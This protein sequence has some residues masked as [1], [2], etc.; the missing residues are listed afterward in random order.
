LVKGILTV[1]KVIELGP[2]IATVALIMLLVFGELL[3]FFIPLGAFMS[4][5]FHLHRL[6]AEGETLAFFTLGFSLRNFLKPFLVF[7]VIITLLEFVSTFWITPLAKRA[8]K[9]VKLALIEKSLSQPFPEKRPVFLG[10]KRC[11]YIIQ[12]SPEGKKEE[13][14]GVLLL[15]KSS[16]K[17]GLFLSKRGVVKDKKEDFT[18]FD[19]WGFFKKGEELEVIKFGSYHFGINLKE[20]KENLSYSRGEKTLKELKKEL[21]ILRNQ[22]RKEYYKYLGEY[23]YRIFNAFIIFPLLSIGFFLGFLLKGVQKLGTFFLGIFCYMLFFMAYNFLVSL[24]EAGT[25]YPAF[26]YLLFYFLAGSMVMIEYL[27]LK[28]REGVAI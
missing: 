19:G 24:G 1:Q 13:L 27:F 7:C 25:I 17:V 12:V 11:L 28:K 9:G 4:V 15:E 23:Y 20:M 5:L 10:S 18:L 14:K 3:G 22:D 6:Q 21:K 26:S 16:S 2:S 8:Q